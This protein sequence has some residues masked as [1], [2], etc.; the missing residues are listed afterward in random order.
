MD[1]RTAS[2]N[3]HVC[4]QCSK[5]IDRRS[6]CIGCEGFCRDVFHAACVKMSAE[7]LLK[8][9]ESNNFWWMCNSC[10]DLMVKKRNDRHMLLKE[11]N[12]EASAPKHKEITRIDDDIAELKQQIAVIHQSLANSAVVFSRA[13]PNV[14][15]PSLI[16]NNDAAESSPVSLP[17]PDTQVGTKATT[18]LSCIVEQRCTNDRFWLFL[19]G[20]KNCVHERD[21]LEL[22]T[23]ALGTDDVFVKKLVPAWKDSLSMPF[24]SFKIGINVRLKGKALLPSTWPSGLRFREF[25]NN[26]WEPL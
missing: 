22:A 6:N 13:E 5:S 25:R 10:S 14:D 24:I 7:D 23:D 26:Y 19:T 17:V 12:C 9:R 21:I 15:S 4:K 3:I 18:R 11:A 16:T 20:I 2:G 1:G 8:Y